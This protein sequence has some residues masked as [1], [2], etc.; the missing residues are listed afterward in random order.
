PSKIKKQNPPNRKI[1]GILTEKGSS[2]F[3]KAFRQ[4]ALAHFPQKGRIYYRRRSRRAGRVKMG[5]V[6]VLR[7]RAQRLDRVRLRIQNLSNS[8][9]KVKGKKQGKY[10]TH[11]FPRIYK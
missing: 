11:Q 7:R 6:E 3:G 5:L 10:I 2:L 4:N 9:Q 8:R 1:W